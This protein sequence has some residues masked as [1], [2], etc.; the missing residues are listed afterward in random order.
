[1]ASNQLMKTPDIPVNLVRAKAG[2]TFMLGTVKIRVMEDGSNTHDRIGSAEFTVPPHTEGPPKHWHEMH[3]ETFLVLSGKL[4]FHVKDGGIVDCETGDYVTVPVRSP[5]TFLNPFDEEC[6]FFN[7][8]TPSYYINYFKVLSQLLEPGKPM[9]PE[10]NKK[11]MAY[12]A[13]IGV[14]DGA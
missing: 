9:D 13:T 14:S 11:A 5:H 6:R 8:F 1:M 12:F 10:A 2:E 7:T 3:D 4:R